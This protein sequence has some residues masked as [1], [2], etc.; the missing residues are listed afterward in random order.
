VTTEETPI[1]SI[2][3]K[4]ESIRTVEPGRGCPSFLLILKG[5][6]KALEIFGRQEEMLLEKGRAGRG[7]RSPHKSCFHL[8]S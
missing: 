5:S 6:G 2:R 7:I 1:P 4:E 8:L 3:E